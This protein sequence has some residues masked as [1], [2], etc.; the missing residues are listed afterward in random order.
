MEEEVRNSDYTTAFNTD[1]RSLSPTASPEHC[2]PSTRACVT[3]ASST[4]TQTNSRARYLNP[5]VAAAVSP[6]SRLSPYRTT[7][8]QVLSPL[9]SPTEAI[10]ASCC[11]TTIVFGVAYHHC[12][13]RCSA[14]TAPFTAERSIRRS[15][16][17]PSS[18][19]T[20]ACRAACLG[21]RVSP[22]RRAVTTGVMSVATT[23]TPSV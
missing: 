1:F 2:L 5:G 20:T 21:C 22:G 11:S 15:F 14:P 18:F 9:A 19:T 8:S 23:R 4:S 7:P 6:T 16:G 12:P 13:L 17:P 3:S 10:S